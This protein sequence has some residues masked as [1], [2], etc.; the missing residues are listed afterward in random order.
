MGNLSTGCQYGTIF[1]DYSISLNG[2]HLKYC[3]KLLVGVQGLN[4]IE[5]SEY[6]STLVQDS[7][8]L[9]NTAHPKLKQLVLKDCVTVGLSNAQVEG[10]LYDP[11][12]LPNNWYFQY[13]SLTDD[14]NPESKLKRVSIDNGQVKIIT[15][16]PQIP[17]PI[18]R[19]R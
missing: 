12:E 17:R 10:V 19:P 18:A 11:T 2:A 7:F 8:Q 15:A 13:K 16:K 9:T 3:W 14:R 5:D 4:M 6:L 1:P